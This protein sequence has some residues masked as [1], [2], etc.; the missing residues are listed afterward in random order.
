MEGTNFDIR[1]LMDYDSI[2]NILINQPTEL[3][4]FEIS[5]ILINNKI[6][7]QIKNKKIKGTKK[8]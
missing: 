8:N 1:E 4:L 2:K 6:N 5:C 7:E 3:C